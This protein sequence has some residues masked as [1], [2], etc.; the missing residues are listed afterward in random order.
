VAASRSCWACRWA[1]PVNARLRNQFGFDVQAASKV[2][3]SVV[4]V[5]PPGQAAAATPLTSEAEVRELARPYLLPTEDL[6]QPPQGR[7]TV[8]FNPGAR[9]WYVIQSE[10]VEG[11]PRLRVLLKLDDESREVLRHEVRP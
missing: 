1:Q 3:L 8:N 2:K 7:V 6:T 11:V 5:P 9:A 10:E 4:A